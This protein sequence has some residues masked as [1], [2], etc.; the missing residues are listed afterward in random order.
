MECLTPA[1]S[2]MGTAADASA[3][4]SVQAHLN[5]PQR[6]GTDGQLPRVDKTGGTD[7]VETMVS[8]ALPTTVLDARA[9]PTPPTLD[10]HGFALLPHATSVNFDDLGRTP[11]PPPTHHS[12][13]PSLL[14]RRSGAR[15]T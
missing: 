9:L 6:Q 5:F 8:A 13:T 2:A 15:T 12:P 1:P 11:A 4:L 7:G 14:Q 3:A 10:R